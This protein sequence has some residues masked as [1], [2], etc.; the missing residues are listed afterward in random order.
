MNF[1][2]GSN[3]GEKRGFCENLKKVKIK[4]K[5]R[6]KTKKEKTSKDKK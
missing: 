6:K 3:L 5:R 2:F 1:N 4:I